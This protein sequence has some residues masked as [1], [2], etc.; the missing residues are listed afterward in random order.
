[1]QQ[2]SPHKYSTEYELAEEL[3]VSQRHLINLR[4]RRLIP[5]LK[6]GR[7]IRYDRAAVEKALEKLTI[8]EIV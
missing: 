5:H 2:D 6:L 1:M 4:N 8:K 3:R 7:L